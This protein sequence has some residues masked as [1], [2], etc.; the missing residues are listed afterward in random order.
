MRDHYNIIL[1]DSSYFLFRNQSVRRG[2]LSAPK[3]AGSFIQSIVKL[4]RESHITFDV[5]F[6]AF[7]NRPYHRTNILEG[8]YKD[9]REDF[10]QEDIDN[11]NQEIDQAEG[12]EKVK[13]ENYR[14]HMIRN[15]NKLK[16]RTEAINI[17]RNLGEFGLTVL[18]YPGY[19]AD[20]LARI[21]VDLYG[22]KYSILLFSIDSDWAGLVSDNVDYLRVRHKGVK[23]FYNIQTQKGF[24]SYISMVEDGLEDM[25]LAWYLEVM[26]AMGIGHNDMRKCWDPNIPIT[27]GEIMAHWDNLDALMDSH[28]FDV[29]TFRLQLST[30]DIKSFPDYAEVSNDILN[31][32]YNLVDPSQVKSK[33]NSKFIF[34]L[35]TGINYNYY[36]KLYESI[37]NYSLLQLRR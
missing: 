5:G 29:D 32:Q 12:D 35:V 28:G 23:D 24:D 17:L 26:E 14:D 34:E 36:R 37:R 3:L 30:F 18:R 33:F 19:E 11:I 6:L 7:D 2:D 13:L 16:V 22:S 4:V 1:F 21:I 31:L 10:S 9:S 8:K 27:L 15:I 20:D 25:G